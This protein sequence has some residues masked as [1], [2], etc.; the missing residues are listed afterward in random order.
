[1]FCEA[2]RWCGTTV[3]TSPMRAESG[4]VGLMRIVQPHRLRTCELSSVDTGPTLRGPK[5]GWITTEHPTR[6]RSA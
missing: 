1:M 6:A 2:G 3:R 5:N 4:G